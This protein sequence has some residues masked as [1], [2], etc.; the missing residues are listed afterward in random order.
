MGVHAHLQQS[1]HETKTTPASVHRDVKSA[2]S[3]G[4]HGV[5]LARDYN[6]MWLENLAAAGEAIRE[7]FPQAAG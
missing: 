4:A 3:A 1:L 2:F 7:I 5:I 6:E